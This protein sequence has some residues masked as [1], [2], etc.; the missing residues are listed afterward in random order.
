M[1]NYFQRE[2]DILVRFNKRPL[3]TIEKSG[4][5]WAYL[6]R[7]CDRAIRWEFGSLQEVKSF[8]TEPSRI[9]LT[10]Y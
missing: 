1:L 5:L 2:N 6:P 8:L 4:R 3:G 7:A 10:R 9:S